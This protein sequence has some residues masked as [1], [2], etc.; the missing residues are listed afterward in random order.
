MFAVR[1]VLSQ[2]V[3]A[4][5]LPPDDRAWEALLDSRGCSQGPGLSFKAIRACQ[6]AGELSLA[7]AIER[8]GRDAASRPSAAEVIAMLVRGP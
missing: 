2:L 6:D 1:L 5:V 3:L 4:T 8:C 7:E